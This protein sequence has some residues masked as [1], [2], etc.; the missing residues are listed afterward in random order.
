MP[1]RW[2]DDLPRRHT[3]GI[4]ADLEFATKPQLAT[5]Q[6]E[7]LTAAGLPAQWV[8]FDEVYGRSEHLRKTAARAGL[9]YAAIIP[10]DYPVTTPAGATTRADAAVT[11]AVFERR[12]C[13]NGSKG[14]R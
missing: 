7:R 3:A 12:S 11:H 4:P 10:C 8:A 2:A 1:A 14:P 9:A 6:L 5:R 13:G